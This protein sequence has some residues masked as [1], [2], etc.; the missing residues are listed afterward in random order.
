VCKDSARSA[1]VE[2]SFEDSKRTKLRRESAFIYR[3]LQ[4]ITE[5]ER[6]PFGELRSTKLRRESIFKER[7][8]KPEVTGF[9]A[10]GARTEAF[11]ILPRFGK[12]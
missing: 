11:G 8:Q 10:A 6:R 2:E 7:R 1:G 12:K 4:V 9:V 5:V 3:A